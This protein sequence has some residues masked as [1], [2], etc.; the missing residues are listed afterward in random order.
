[1]NVI[2]TWDTWISLIFVL[3]WSSLLTRLLLYVS[4]GPHG[5][6]FIIAIYS[7]LVPVDL[8]QLY[9]WIFST[10]LHAKFSGFTL[11]MERYFCIRDSWHYEIAKQT[12]LMHCV[13]LNAIYMFV[14]LFLS[15]HHEVLMGFCWSIHGT[16]LKIHIGYCFGICWL[17]FLPDQAQDVPYTK[18]AGMCKLNSNVN[19]CGIVQYVHMRVYLAHL[20]LMPKRLCN[21]ELSIVCHPALLLL[22]SLTLL[23]WVD[24]PLKHTSHHRRFIFYIF[25]HLC[26]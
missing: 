7:S 10:L 11:N 2:W 1:M 14:Y 15:S 6:I 25:M 9:T 12:C 3:H 5:P 23:S 13:T 24:S 16:N 26:P 18:S 4:S 22:S 21:H 20:S 19:L 17:L 8:V